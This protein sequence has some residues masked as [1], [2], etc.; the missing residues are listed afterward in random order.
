MAHQ[1][2]TFIY[3]LSRQNLRGKISISNIQ[4]VKF[5][6]HISLSSQSLVPISQ[7]HC[8]MYPCIKFSVLHLV[9]YYII[10]QGHMPLFIPLGNIFA[11][12][13]LSIDGTRIYWV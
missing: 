10:F 4:L 13:E 8:N 2:N 6:Q 5:D 12:P 3:Y 9:F 7:E 1:G 11:S